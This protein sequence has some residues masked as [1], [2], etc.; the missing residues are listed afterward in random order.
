MIDLS[1]NV[2]LLTIPEV[3]KILRISPTGVRRLQAARH[4]PF[5][6]VGGSIRFLREDIQSYVAR[7]RVE[8]ITK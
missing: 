7:Q 3:A 5:V 2:E 8:A 6:K 4:I 1:T